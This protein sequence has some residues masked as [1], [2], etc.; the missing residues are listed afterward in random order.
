MALKAEGL[1]APSLMPS[2]GQQ[3][4]VFVFPHLLPAFLDDT[5]Q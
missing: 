2:L 5:A 4:F 1:S 3:F